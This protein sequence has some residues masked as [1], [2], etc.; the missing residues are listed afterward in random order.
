MIS[1]GARTSDDTFERMA[2]AG[3]VV[4]DVVP[5][6]APFGAVT[7]VTLEHASGERF[8]KPTL[9][10]GFGYGPT[11]NRLGSCIN[12]GEAWT[13][14]MFASL[15]ER[16]QDNAHNAKLLASTH[17]RVEGWAHPDLLGYA[18]QGVLVDKPD[19]MFDTERLHRFTVQRNLHPVVDAR[20]PLNPDDWWMHPDVVSGAI[21]CR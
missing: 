10:W 5:K 12:V 17:V 14:E 16:H 13:R 8:S 1:V 9:L 21:R 7:K 20:L 6:S 18:L 4:P 15:K 19:L 2:L 11:R 3:L